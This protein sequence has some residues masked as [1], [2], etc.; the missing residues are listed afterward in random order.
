MMCL[1][2]Q[3][4]TIKNVIELT[5]EKCSFSHYNCTKKTPT[6]DRTKTDKIA[7]LPQGT[8]A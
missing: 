8:T 5:T 6:R 2:Q 7:V 1:Q 3:Q 4:T